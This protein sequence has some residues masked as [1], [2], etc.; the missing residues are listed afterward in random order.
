MSYH[1]I[2][3]EL[4]QGARGRFAQIT[5]D[6]QG[7]SAN[8][9]SQQMIGELDNALDEI[10][11]SDA[12][13]GLIIRSAKP[14]GFVFGADITEFETLSTLD[15]VRA[16]Q[17]KAL[18][19][20]ARLEAL[21]LVSVALIHG[22]ALG[23]GLELALACDYRLCY[24]T[25]RIMAGFPEANLG[26]MPGFAGTARAARLI[27]GKASLAL[28]LS[29]KPLTTQSQILDCGLADGLTDEAGALAQAEALM[30][31][32]KRRYDAFCDALDWPS[33]TQQAKAEY[34]TGGNPGSIHNGYSLL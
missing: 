25:G 18:M 3:L 1:H 14:S 11:A 22:P 21:R 10:E 15:E 23:G 28:C 2:T 27:G 5:L 16:L 6:Y 34:I 19:M 9:L 17:D 24:E 29:A 20:L 13:I 4:C 8:V 32:G 33:L 26:L 30:A 7:K 12:L 31:K